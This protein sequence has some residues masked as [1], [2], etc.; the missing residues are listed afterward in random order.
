MPPLSDLQ[1]ALFEALPNR[2]D[3]A[4]VLGELGRHPWPQLA[5]PRPVRPY[6]GASVA[7]VVVLDMGEAE[8][9]TGEGCSQRRDEIAVSRPR[10]EPIQ[11]RL[12]RNR[13][14]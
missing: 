7:P 9:E 3:V 5:D 12:Q 4:G 2:L 6:H 8:V 10:V 13:I 14:W 11:Q 1:I